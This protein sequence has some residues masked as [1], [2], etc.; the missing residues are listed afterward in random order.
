MILP[1]FL[2]MVAT[3]GV[4]RGVRRVRELRRSA[5]ALAERPHPARAARVVLPARGSLA[6]EPM[7]RLQRAEQALPELLSHLST[8]VPRG[9]LD[10]VSVAAA[11]AAT[12]LRHRA[13]Q[14]RAVEQARDSAPPLERAPL[15]DAVRALRGQ[16]DSGVDEYARLV[17]AAGRTVAASSGASA[18]APALPGSPPP[19]RD[20]ALADAAD[21]LAALAAALEE[22]G[23]AGTTG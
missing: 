12:G 17:A 14:L 15:I 19:Q 8:A 6:R 20:L 13:A 7:L 21:R 4:L 5:A 3:F 11:D 2:G 23:P 1:G 10:E 9:A 16:L 18:P 22:L